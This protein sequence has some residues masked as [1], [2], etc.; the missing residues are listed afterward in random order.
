MFIKY[1]NLVMMHNSSSLVVP[2]NLKYFYYKILSL[3]PLFKGVINVIQTITQKSNIGHEDDNKRYKNNS[4]TLNH[5]TT[6]ISFIANHLTNTEDKFLLRCL[7]M[8][9]IKTIF[10]F[11][12]RCL[13]MIMI[14]IIFKFLL[15]GFC[16]FGLFCVLYFQFVTLFLLEICYSYTKYL[17][18]ILF[19]N[20]KI[21]VNNNVNTNMNI[22]YE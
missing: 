17:H 3:L 4:K 16:L 2:S 22:A 5:M 6:Q 10:R 20:K 9:M 14:K 7:L 12:L 1:Q 19:T 21:F 13:L 18:Q 11:L 8:I 15:F